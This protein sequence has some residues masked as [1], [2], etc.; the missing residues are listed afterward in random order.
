MARAQAGEPDGLAILAEGQTAARGSRGRSW[1][2]TAG[3]LYLSILLRP[4][5][6][7]EARGLGQWALLAGVVLIE[8]LRA[9]EPE[10][11]VL[12]LKWPN[13]VLREG[14]KLA[15]ILLDASAG[16][17]G[18]DWLVIGLGANLAEPP[19]VAGRRTAALGRYAAEHGAEPAAPRAV[20]LA[21]LERLEQWRHR[22]AVEG[23]APVRAAWLA[24]AHPLGT[25]IT[26]SD[27]RGARGGA[28]A[29]LSPEGALLLE[30]PDGQVSTMST[31][32]VL[33]G[34]RV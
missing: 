1:A 28:F 4:R 34:R 17:D 13:D 16:A 14:A 27:A 10:A 25:P 18:L 23:F 11:G 30:G 9:F 3:N 12:S 8:T 20:T 32:D 2:G 21:L 31:G 29:G 26:V 15:G 7:V 33:L 22:L 19:V 24:A 6:A 5:N